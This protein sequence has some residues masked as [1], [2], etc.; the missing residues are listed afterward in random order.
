MKYG[1]PIFIYTLGIIL[2]FYN[3]QKE[4]YCLKIRNKK[5]VLRLNCYIKS[6]LAYHKLFLFSK[7]RQSMSGVHKQRAIKLYIPTKYFV[8][9]M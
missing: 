5:N 1:T 7:R 6:K 8:K 4:F 2:S 9:G 3:V